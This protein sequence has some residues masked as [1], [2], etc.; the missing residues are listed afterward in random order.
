MSKHNFHLNCRRLLPALLFYW[1]YLPLSFSL[2]LSLSLSCSVTAA[3]SRSSGPSEK[4]S[5]DC[6]SS[7]LHFCN[8]ILAKRHLHLSALT[9]ALLSPPSV[10]LHAASARSDC[11]P[12]IPHDALCAKCFSQ[13]DIRFV[14]AIQPHNSNSTSSHKQLLCVSALR[15]R[16]VRNRFRILCL[17]R[18]LRS[19]STSLFAS[20][21]S[22]RQSSESV[23]WNIYRN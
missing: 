11:P 9:F 20:P 13:R 22:N 2:A 8:F 15:I 19:I 7:V 21:Q 5:R 16:N 3:C 4:D 23:K 6:S 12:P 1:R 10:A 17:L 18:A 14:S